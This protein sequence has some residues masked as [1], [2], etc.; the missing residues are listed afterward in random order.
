[1]ENLGNVCALN[2]S[3]T[4]YR[5]L[6]SVVAALISST[7]LA[8]GGTAVAKSLNIFKAGNYTKTGVSLSSLAIKD[9]RYASKAENVAGLLDLAQNENRIEP[10]KAMQLSGPFSRL[11]H[12][13]ELLLT[14]LKSEKCDPEVFP[15]VAQPFIKHQRSLAGA[16][17]AY[18]AELGSK[19]GGTKEIGI[20]LGGRTLPDAVIEDTYLR[21]AVQQSK[22]PMAEATGM[23]ARLRG[24]PGFRSTLSK[25][26]GASDIKTSGHLNELRIANN[27]PPKGFKVEGI[28]S[29]FH[30]PNKLA[31]TDID[32]LLERNGKIIAIEAKDY[33][34]D[35]MIPMDKFRADMVSLNEYAKAN[36]PSRVLQVFSMTNK[37]NNEVSQRLL[38]IEAERHGVELIYGS[39]S[40][41][42]TQIEQLL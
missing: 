36:G 42:I 15:A 20:L 22:I 19:P 25:T 24:T 6:V 13:D 41:V 12:G 27:A 7:A 11:R 17:I 34:P 33:A 14:C 2:S 23:M 8:G 35:T 3:G 16:E 4:V 28:G 37:P 31:A 38:A 1:M 21:I 40:E 26:I 10:I 5:F 32:V 9:L 30:D 39:P 29:S 18:L